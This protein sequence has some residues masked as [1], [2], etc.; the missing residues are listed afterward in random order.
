MRDRQRHAELLQ[1]SGHRSFSFRVGKRK[2]QRN[3]NRLGTFPLNS[4]GQR[5]QILWRRRVQ[6]FAVAGG[7]FVHAKT[8]I[9]RDQ[10]FYAIKE[11]II[12]LGTG[13]A[14]DLDRVFKT[15][16]RDQSH[17]CAFALQQSIGADRG[18]MQKNQSTR[19]SRFFPGPRQSPAKDRMEWRKP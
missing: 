16:G 5:L 13:L 3:S 19:D 6:D 7:A 15:G 14:A 11:E 18:A 1:G 9:R 12:K 10:R 8:Q 17:A 4:V 2:Q